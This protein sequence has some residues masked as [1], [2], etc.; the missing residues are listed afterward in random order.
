MPDEPSAPG[1]SPSNDPFEGFGCFVL[2]FVGIVGWVA[3]TI[4]EK[5]ATKGAAMAGAVAVCG[6]AAMVVAVVFLGLKYTAPPR[7]PRKDDSG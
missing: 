4:F 7:A 6:L 1:T 2:V 5:A 3:I